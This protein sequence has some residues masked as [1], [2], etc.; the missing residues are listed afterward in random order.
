MQNLKSVQKALM[1]NRALLRVKTVQVLYSYYKSA[2]KTIPV[3]EKELFHSIEK[4]YDL[5]FH[6]LQLSVEITNF[7]SQRIELRRA[8]LRPTAEDLSPN[9][10]FVDNS[11]V[12]QLSDNL[13][14][15]EYLTKH[16]LS[17]VNNPEVIKELFE[18]LISTDFYAAYMN[19]ETVDYAADKDIWRKIYKKI[20]LQNEELDSSLEDQS[21]YWVDDIEMVVSFIIKTIKR[22]DVDKGTEQ[23]LLPM[24]KD[25]EDATFARKLM[26]SVLDNGAEYRELIDKNTENWELDRIAFMDI[27]IMEVA[28]AE[29]L[30]FPTIPI[31][32][33]LNE[34]IELAK[35]YSTSKSGPF[36]NGVLDN[37]VTQLK[38]ENKLIKV[39]MFSNTNKK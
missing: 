1:I 32:V 27:L 23:P 19:A 29:L 37:I 34:Y 28:L 13:Y 6:L 14:F 35:N 36:I 33:T 17:W 39:M 38:N 15:K 10:R 5:Y 3:V 30:E 20:V 9:M 4:T 26:R 7:A 2:G 12:K 25:E 8:K 31:N 18:E 21:I 16:K 22:F 24:F 11:F